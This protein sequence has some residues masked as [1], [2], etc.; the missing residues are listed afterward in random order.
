[1]KLNSHVNRTKNVV[2]SY[3]MCHYRTRETKL[4]NCVNPNL[5]PNSNSNSNSIPTLTLTLSLTLTRSEKI[6]RIIG[7][8]YSSMSHKTLE[9]GWQILAKCLLKCFAQDDEDSREITGNIDNGEAFR[10]E[11]VS[12]KSLLCKNWDIEILEG[13]LCKD[14]H[15][16]TIKIGWN[17]FHDA[18]ARSTISRYVNTA[19]L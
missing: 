10:R 19:E 1:M 18:Q 13:K 7:D 5:N 8:E 9:R 16:N 11:L 17:L 4:E 14:K 15:R 2:C 12:S 3:D 6:E